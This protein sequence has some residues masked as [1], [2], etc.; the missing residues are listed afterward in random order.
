MNSRENGCH[1]C[2]YFEPHTDPKFNRYT[3]YCNKPC[4]AGSVEFEV[5]EDIWCDDWKL[6]MP[7]YIKRWKKRI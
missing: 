1:N 3:G 6:K 7:E 5:Y 2:L 4:T